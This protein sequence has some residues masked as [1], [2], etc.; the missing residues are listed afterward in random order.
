MR[1]T[2]RLCSRKGRT[3]LN[4]GRSS[5]RRGVYIRKKASGC[6]GFRGDRNSGPDVGFDQV[7]VPNRGPAEQRNYEEGRGGRRTQ[8]GR[9]PSRHNVNLGCRSD[10]LH[11]VNRVG[12]SI[13]LKW[14][15][16]G[17]HFWW[18]MLALFWGRKYASSILRGGKRC[19]ANCFFRHR[20]RSVCDW[21]ILRK[22]GNPVGPTIS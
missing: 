9:C 14:H 11:R 18:E 8:E 21:L 4:L 12:G 7:K 22:P 20:I 17:T 15:R 5:Q 6:I 19:E 16:S 2:R 10:F 3:S 13:N 1:P